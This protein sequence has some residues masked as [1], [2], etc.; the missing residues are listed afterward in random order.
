MI[1]GKK[2]KVVLGKMQLVPKKIH[3]TVYHQGTASVARRYYEGLG[4]DTMDAIKR[5]SKQQA[6][7]AGTGED[8]VARAARKIKPGRIAKGLAPLV[9]R[10]VLR[11][12]PLIGTG[13]AILEFADNVEAHGIGGAI[14]RSTPILGDLIS[15]HDV[16]TDLAKQIVDDANAKADAELKAMNAPVDQA[17]DLANQQTLNAYRTLAPQID[18]TNPPEYGTGTLV[19]P[20]EIADALNTYRIRMM[21]ANHLR[22]TKKKGFNYGAAAAGNLQE[23]KQALQRASQRRAVSPTQGPLM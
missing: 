6:L 16:G 12:I 21:N 20:Q 15:A 7:L 10:T 14:A 4:S 1:D 5:V 23:L 17:R 9:G 19:D 22:I 8:F 13:L 2:T 11:A 3:K 18:V